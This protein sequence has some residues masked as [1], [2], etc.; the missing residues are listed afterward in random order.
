MTAPIILGCKALHLQVDDVGHRLLVLQV[1][2][3]LSGLRL[4]AADEIPDHLMIIEAPLWVILV[5]VAV[6][7]PH[8]PATSVALAH[9]HTVLYD[10]FGLWLG[11][12]SP[13]SG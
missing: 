13:L 5:W 9:W 11:A 12:E 4:R 3:V 1:L 10:L 8:L 6:L 7:P 2:N